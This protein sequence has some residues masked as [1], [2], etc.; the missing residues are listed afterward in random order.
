M[1]SGISGVMA[2]LKSEAL[3]GESQLFEQ[4][5]KLCAD[6]QYETADGRLAF[7]DYFNTLVQAIDA[8]PKLELEADVAPGTET[9][10]QMELAQ[11][12]ERIVDECDRIFRRL[13]HF[14]GKLRQ[15]EDKV[16]NQKA[17]FVAWYM[18]A[19]LALVKDL[20]LKLP[21]AEVRKLGEAEFSRHMAGLDA[22]LTYLIEAVKIEASKVAHHKSAQRE[23]YEYGQDQAN[24]V[25]TSTLPAFGGAIPEGRLDQRSAVQEPDEEDTP[26]S[27]TQPPFAIRDTLRI[28]KPEEPPK[29]GQDEIK[30]TFVKTGDPKPVT[31]IEDDGP[32]EIRCGKTMCHRHDCLDCYPP[33]RH[34]NKFMDGEVPKKP[35]SPR[36]KLI[37]DDEEVV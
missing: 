32:K 7:G 35:L 8:I 11:S 37:L 5:K 25:W 19:A 21:V 1:S 14:S 30:G 6:L 27:L 34:Y 26:P 2:A 29:V 36:R 16:N 12:A 10:Y 33:D 13:N 3:L 28:L 18:L 9:T 15:A 4:I 20:D 22:A 23:K 17:E 31:A 24:A